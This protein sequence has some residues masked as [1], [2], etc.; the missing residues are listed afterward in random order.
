MST[1]KYYAL[2]TYEA[3]LLN[4]TPG[5]KED[6]TE[7]QERETSDLFCYATPEKAGRIIECLDALQGIPDPA[8]ALQQAREALRMTLTHDDTNVHYAVYKALEALG[9]T[10]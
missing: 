2:D 5:R 4:E 7:I 1:G 3:L 6:V 8:A 10:P 9:G